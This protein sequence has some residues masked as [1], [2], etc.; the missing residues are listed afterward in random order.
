MYNLLYYII[1]CINVQYYIE[2]NTVL[3]LERLIQDRHYSKHFNH[4]TMGPR[5]KAVIPIL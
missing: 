2:E 1:Q 3:F 4:V 5:E